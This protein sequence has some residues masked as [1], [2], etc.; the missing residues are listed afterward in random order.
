MA[1]SGPTLITGILI[2]RVQYCYLQ[3]MTIC[4]PILK[5]KPD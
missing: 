1:N 3:F 5:E 2:R 4:Y